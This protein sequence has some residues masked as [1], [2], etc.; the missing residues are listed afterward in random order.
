M[1]LHQGRVADA[2][3]ALA[4]VVNQTR[5]WR[6]GDDMAVE[7]YAELLVCFANLMRSTLETTD[8]SNARL[9]VIDHL[10][11]RLQSRAGEIKLR[12]A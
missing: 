5:L 2:C 8:N 3:A 9:A 7:T 4:E 6:S 1:Y 12:H 10:V 11:D